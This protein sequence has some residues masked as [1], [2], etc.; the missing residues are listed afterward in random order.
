MV[1]PKLDENK[2]RT[3]VNLH[4]SF[5]ERCLL[6][7][8]KKKYGYQNL[9]AYMRDAGIH[10]KLFIEEIKGKEEIMK[11]VDEDIILIRQYLKELQKI[12]YRSELSKED[13]NIIKLQN[14]EIIKRTNDLVKKVVKSL[15]TQIKYV[16]AD[17]YELNKSKEDA[18]QEGEN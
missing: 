12:L 14:D 7:D 4:L 6:E 1:R 5:E 8:K 18:E 2:K 9:S 10:E 17:E 13:I 15:S 16:S 3:K 11:S